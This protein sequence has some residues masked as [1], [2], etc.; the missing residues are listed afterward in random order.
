MGSLLLTSLY[1]L[2]LLHSQHA[3]GQMECF[4]S[5]VTSDCSEATLYWSTLRV[6]VRGEDSGFS[7]TDRDHSTLSED[8]R[9]MFKWDT[10]ELSYSY[11][12]GDSAV[13]Y[14]ALPEQFLGSKLTAY[15]G[16]LTV[17]QRAV[18]S[19]EPVE[20]S[21]VIMT[22]NGLNLHYGL[23]GGPRT[24]GQEEKN[25]IMLKEDGWFVLNSGVPVPATK[26][27]F[28]KVLS[29]IESLLVR[30]TISREMDE[31]MIRKVMMDISVPQ[32]TG[33]P[34]ASGVEEC[35]CPEGYS[36]LSCEQCDTGYYRDESDISS[37]PLGAC[38]PCPCNDNQDSCTQ[39]VQAQQVVCVCKEGWMGDFCDS[40]DDPSWPPTSPQSYPDPPPYPNPQSYPDP[41]SIQ[42]QDP[43]MYPEPSSDPIEVKI[44][45]PKV[46]TVRPG[47]TVQFDCSARPKFRT[48]DPLVFAWAKE[49]GELPPGRCTDSGYGLLI[50]T[51]VETTDS[52][53]YVCTVTAGTFMVRQALELQVEDSAPVPPSVT[54]DPPYQQATEGDT[55][56]FDCQASGSP[57]PG[58]SWS[59]AG[60]FPLGR[61]ARVQGSRLLLEFVQIEDEGEYVCKAGNTAGTEEARAQLYVE[62]KQDRDRDL[63]AGIRPWEEN[64]P[65]PGINV[66]NSYPEDI[67]GQ[68]RYPEEDNVPPP[69]TYPP[70]RGYQEEDNNQD[71]S[72]Y[73]PPDQGQRYPDPAQPRYAPA[74]VCPPVTVTIEP[75]E[76]TIPQGSSTQLKCVGSG[77]APALSWEKVGEDLSSPALSISAGVISV[78]SAAVRDRGMYVCTA[79]TACGSGR[80]SSILEVEPREIPTVEMYPA[81]DQTVTKGESVLFQ[82]RYMSGIPTPIISWARADGRPMPPNAELLSGGVL[83]MNSVTGAEAG[84]FR[85]RAENAAGSVETMATLRI[86]ELPSIRLE[87]EGSVTLMVG[88]PLTIKCLAT[89]DPTP[90]IT[91]K[92]MGISMSELGTTSPTLEFASLNKQDEGTYSCVA[93]NTAGQM[94]DRLQ[95]IVAEN[96][97]YLQ[98]PMGYPQNRYSPE[99]ENRYNVDQENIYP[100]EPENRYPPQ[101][102]NRDQV[103]P[104][105]QYPPDPLNTPEDSP[106]Q[107]SIP[108]VEHEVN[109]RE[110]MNVDLTCM[111]IG[112]MPVNTQTVWT[113]ADGSPIARRH[114]KADGVLHIRGAKKSDEG[115]YLCQMIE[116]GG[117]ILFQLNAN[118]VVQDIRPQPRRPELV[119][120]SPFNWEKPPIIRPPPRYPDVQ[121]PAACPDSSWRCES[122]DCIPQSARCDGYNDC[123][124]STDELDCPPISQTQDKPPQPTSQPLPAVGNAILMSVSGPT[125]TVV[126]PGQTVQFLCQAV[127]TVELEDPLTLQWVRDNEDLPPGRCRDDGEGGLEIGKVQPVDSGVYICV[128]TAGRFINTARATL[129]VGGVVDNSQKHPAKGYQQPVRARPQPGQGYQSPYAPPQGAFDTSG[130]P[131]VG[132]GGAA[133]NIP[134][135]DDEYYDDKED[136]DYDDYDYDRQPHPSPYDQPGQQGQSCTSSQFQ[137]EN[138]AQCVPASQRCDGEFDCMDG[139]DETK[140]GGRG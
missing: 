119:G 105:N 113:R 32:N 43:R 85:C 16:N 109:T 15:G 58:V 96:E 133:S 112:S 90:Q 98:P 107:P 34:P 53:T 118:L 74:E 139:S 66:G 44:S 88:S 50:I 21:E 86:Q 108:A 101:S 55:V 52:G 67:Q 25:K 30:T 2:V 130:Y 76:Q 138:M 17:F 134:V 92:K 7:L 132:Q 71:S 48:Q 128:A 100:P 91:W 70:P 125:D 41:Q 126:P 81:D 18:F 80:A 24:S 56:F 39:D 110:G 136:E 22:G 1:L 140:C 111:N 103:D 14:W 124:D 78:R 45:G 135:P 106:S 114:K 35:Q 54:I 84:Q 28:I 73:P 72:R 26:E 46:Q 47:E 89:G 123:R 82:C 29:N 60:G 104:Y 20:D 8:I 65:I 23:G 87:P 42:T 75:S 63:G 33:G 115:L 36:G 3:E 57:Q 62:N 122:G 117:M 69:P 37:G 137:C 102:R 5:G 10:Y 11:E 121:R 61:R 116:P 40:R 99:P 94:E 31:A 131:P 77:S 97:E 12:P 51:S 27:E 13:Y 68:R 127:P 83:R 64:E 9:P 120:R 79:S 59:R 6:Q 4:C 93:T 19:G 95:V 38:K 49:N 129:A